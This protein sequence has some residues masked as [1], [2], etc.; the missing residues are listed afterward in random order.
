MLVVVVRSL[1]VDSLVSIPE[2]VA[3][4]SPGWRPCVMGLLPTGECDQPHSW[5][6][7]VY[8]STF[9]AIYRRTASFVASR[10][11]G[12]ILS[13]YNLGPA[14]AQHISPQNFSRA[15]DTMLY[16]W[17]NSSSPQLCEIVGERAVL[18]AMMWTRLAQ[19]IVAGA[20]TGPLDDLRN[21]FATALFVYNPVTFTG[22]ISINETQS[23]LLAENYITGSMAREGTHVVP[24]AWTV[25]VYIAVA[26]GILVVISVLLP[27]TAT[28][29]APNTSAF[30]FVDCLSLNRY[31]TGSMTEQRDLMEVFVGLQQGKDMDVLERIANVKVGL[32]NEGN[33]GGPTA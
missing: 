1:Q 4:D 10:S 24:Q 29:K 31:V 3:D 30:P 19:G 27:W 9:I 22:Q 2:S 25:Y 33:Q 20:W 16:P 21:L 7:Y 6:E 17:S 14:E 23:G 8:R 28:Y 12:D 11:T 32:K 26:G 15:I 5:N 18:N 13:V